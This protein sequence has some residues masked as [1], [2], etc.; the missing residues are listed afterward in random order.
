[1]MEAETIFA[2]A[3]GGVTRHR[4]GRVVLNDWVLISLSLQSK[5][6]LQRAGGP[7]SRIE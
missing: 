4:G 6:V 2:A 1:M 3:F 5:K 7:Q